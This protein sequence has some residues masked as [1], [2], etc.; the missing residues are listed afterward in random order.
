MLSKFLSKASQRQLQEKLN[1]ACAAYRALVQIFDSFIP[2]IKKKH[3]DRLYLSRTALWFD[4]VELALKDLMEKFLKEDFCHLLAYGTGK[5]T[6]RSGLAVFSGFLRKLLLTRAI[7]MYNPGKS[8]RDAAS[9]MRSIYESKRCWNEMSSELEL[10]SMKKHKA[11]LTSEKS[12]S[13]PAKNWIERATDVVIPPGTKYFER[14]CVPTWSASFETSRSEGGNHSAVLGEGKVFDLNDL[15][16]VKK[17]SDDLEYRLFCR[18]MEESND[19]KYQAIPEP[20]KY[21][22]ITVGREAIYSSMRSFQGFL[23][24]MW[25]SCSLGTMTDHVMD[26]I[27]RLCDEK[28]E[29][30]FSGDYDSATDALSMEATSACLE[31][32]LKNIGQCNTLMG[33]MARKCLGAAYIHYP[34]GSV[35]LQTRGQLMGNPLSFT[36]LCIINLSTFMRTFTIT[37]RHDPRLK[38]VL[39]NGDD[40]LFKGQKHDGNRWREAADDVGLIVNEAKTY[41]SSRW[42]LINSIFVDMVNKKKIEYIPLSVTLGHNIKRGEITRTL[43]QAPAIWDLI[44]RCPNER[45]R[46]MCRRIYLRT[47]D[48]LCPHLGSFVPNFFVHKDLGGVGIPPPV[49]WKFGISKLQR[50]VA[51]FF[52]RNRAVRALKEKIMELPKA[53]S[54]ALEKL[55]KLKPPSFDWVVKGSPVEGPL[56]KNQSTVDDY[57]ESLLPHCLRSTAYVTGPGS[58]I[59]YELYHEYRRALRW[60]EPSCRIKKIIN[61]LG[62]REICETYDLPYESKNCTFVDPD[63]VSE[64][65]SSSDSENES[66]SSSPTFWSADVSECCKLY[67]EACRDSRE[68]GCFMCRRQHCHEGASHKCNGECEDAFVLLWDESC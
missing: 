40:I 63:E 62:A 51:T 14:P 58:N 22:V 61:Y 7:R 9:F 18:A 21:R 1:R 66:T 48:R 12:I 67:C 42:A 45:S 23:I 4:L 29:I 28:G 60:H 41:E 54:C 57:L 49:G 35:V 17:Y 15:G 44:E 11:L 53:V 65:S 5:T 56:K 30:Y 20:G 36:L 46:D 52:L 64:D 33:A 55:S 13:Q 32:I 6:R 19:V 3:F 50:K 43:G 8:G 31:R 10:D 26:Q 68:G 39:I 25:K 34:D 38:R 27:L 16:Q 2:V 59:D 24:N 47:I 37:G